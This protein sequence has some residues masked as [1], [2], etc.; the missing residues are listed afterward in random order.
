MKTPADFATKLNIHVNQL[1]L[2]VKSVTKQ[3]TTQI[4]KQKIVEEAK[5][6]LLYTDWDIAQVGYKLGFEEPA[7]FNNFF[8]K[9]T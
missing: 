4:I 2:S 3:T 8:K 1:N 7:H 9:H 6:L 5:N